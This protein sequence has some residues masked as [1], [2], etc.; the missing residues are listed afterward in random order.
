MHTN[1]EETMTAHGLANV[2]E[3]IARALRQHAHELETANR[4]KP[5]LQG[6]LSIAAAIFWSYLHGL[7]TDSR[8][9]IWRRENILVLLET[10]QRE[11][12]LFIPNLLQGLSDI[13]QK[14]IP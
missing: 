12:E 10:I 7:L 13:E 8:K 2:L 6:G 3:G 5:A 14:P 4:P 1:R 9:E 11:P